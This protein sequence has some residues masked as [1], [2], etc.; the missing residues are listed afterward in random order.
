MDS[1][2]RERGLIRSRTCEG[3]TGRPYILGHHFIKLLMYFVKSHFITISFGILFSPV[4]LI[5]VI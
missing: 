1:L 2:K 4:K 3:G 5:N